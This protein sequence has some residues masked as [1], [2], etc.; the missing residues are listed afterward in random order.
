LRWELLNKKKIKKNVFNF[1]AKV[2]KFKLKNNIF[3]DKNEK[4]INKNYSFN[5]VSKKNKIIDLNING[6]GIKIR[7]I[8][9]FSNNNYKYHSKGKILID[10]K[11]KNKNQIG[12]LK[13]KSS[14]LI[15]RKNG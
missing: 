13:P 1:I 11:I 5:L 7:L 15:R 8:H 10:S 3:R 9:N 4:K 12:I 6:K 14:I 2:N